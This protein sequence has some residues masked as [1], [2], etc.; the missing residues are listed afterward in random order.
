ME[1]RSKESGDAGY[2]RWKRGVRKSGKREG[3]SVEKDVGI[4]AIFAFESVTVLHC[5]TVTLLH[6]YT[7]TLYTN[8]FLL[9]LFT[10]HSI[11]FAPLG[12][13]VWWVLS[14]L[15]LHSLRSLTRG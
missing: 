9:S 4:I 3:G 7:I 12:D 6:Y 8:S 14:I 13:V 15:G 1:T 11:L 5:D 2:G 10:F